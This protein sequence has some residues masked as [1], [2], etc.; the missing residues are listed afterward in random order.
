M[1]RGPEGVIGVAASSSSA[2]S[3]RRLAGVLVAVVA[4]AVAILV[5]RDVL[6]GDQV[7]RLDS[8]VYRNAINQMLAGGSLYDYQMV[9]F[10]QV[11]PFNYPP[12][13]AIVLMPWALLPVGWSQG[14]WMLVQIVAATIMVGLVLTRTA[15]R[16]LPSGWR[17]IGIMIVA[18]AAFLASA[19]AMQSLLLGQISLVVG[20]LVVIDLLWIPA[21]FRGY[22]TGIAGAIKLYPMIFLPYFLLSRQWRAAAGAGVG[23]VVSTG[24]AWAFLPQE[25]LRYWTVELFATGR[26]GGLDWLRNKSLLG[27]MAHF[28]VGGG[29]YRLWWAGVVLMLFG[30]AMWRAVRHRRRGESVA[31]MLVVGTLAGLMSPI[32]W[33]HH[34]VIVALVPIYLMLL[35]RKVWFIVGLAAVVV[36]NYYSPAVFPGDATSTWQ[37]LAQYLVTVVMVVIAVSGLPSRT[38]RA[39]TATDEIGSCGAHD[40]NHSSGAGG[41]R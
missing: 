4:I 19:A 13:A 20:A 3:D 2:R 11:L 31:A 26:V 34:L 12:F 21:R 32:S 27:L 5:A 17:F 39:T 10:G 41:A 25:S 24:L 36:F 7:L 6:V 1:A 28:E 30:F 35:E 14:L 18:V 38:P 37:E 40:S 23:F 8:T 22:L 16:W 15:P 33:P 9:A 29:S